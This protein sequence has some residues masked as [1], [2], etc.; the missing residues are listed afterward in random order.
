MKDYKSPKVTYLVDLLYHQNKYNPIKQS[1][2][3]KTNN[4][5]EQCTLNRYLLVTQ[6]PS[7]R[8]VIEQ[9]ST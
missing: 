5:C 1:F 6:Y 3:K 8:L 2:K 7:P 9:N 4:S